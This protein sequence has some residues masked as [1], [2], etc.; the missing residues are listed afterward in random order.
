MNDAG[1]LTLIYL[2]AR[3]AYQ[4]TLKRIAEA[5]VLFQTVSTQLTD[6]WTRI[7]MKERMVKAFLKNPGSAGTPI[8]VRHQDWLNYEQLA[9]LLSTARQQWDGQIK[10]Y[11]QIPLANREGLDHPLA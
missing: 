6:N 1:R 10:A 4:E 9:I 5:A 7:E 3:K 2:E 8:Y 11:Q